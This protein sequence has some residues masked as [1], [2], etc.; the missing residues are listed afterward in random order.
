MKKNI[1][2]L[3]FRLWCRDNGYSAQYIAD[4]LHIQRGTVYSYWAGRTAVPDGYKKEL[5]IKLGL[6]IYETFYNLELK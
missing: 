6:P 5:E 1:S 4:V 3:K 2:S